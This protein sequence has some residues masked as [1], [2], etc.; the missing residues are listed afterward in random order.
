[1][2]LQ[3]CGCN[4]DTATTCLNTYSTAAVAAAGD[5]AGTCTAA[6]TMMSCFADTGCC[7]DS[8]QK[9]ALDGLATGYNMICTGDNAVTSGC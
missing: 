1:M 3:G 6:K 4:A 5:V 9:A 7:G 8:D 2:S